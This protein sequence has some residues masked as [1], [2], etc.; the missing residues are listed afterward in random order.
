MAGGRLN[1][2]G[3]LCVDVL[4]AMSV[5]VAVSE[6]DPGCNVK[7]PPIALSVMGAAAP[8]QVALSSPE[9]LSVTVIDVITVGENKAVPD[10]GEVNAST[11][12][13]LS[14]LMAMEVVAETPALLVVVPEACCPK[15]SVVTVTGSGQI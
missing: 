3:T 11:G 12:P 10:T 15:P 7:L 2:T 5:A 13:V 9:R 4:P 8:L 6:F 1:V 14:K